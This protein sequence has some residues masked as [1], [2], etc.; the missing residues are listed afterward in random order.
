MCNKTDK[1]MR[2]YGQYSTYL[3]DMHNFKK[4]KNMRV[5]LTIILSLL[6]LS[7]FSQTIEERE[8]DLKAI[9]SGEQIG[10][11]MTKISELLAVDKF[12]STAIELKLD[13]YN[14][15]N[16]KDSIKIFFDNLIDSNRN[17]PFPYLL[18]VKFARFES[19][20]DDEILNCL[21]TAFSIDSSNVKVNYYLAKIYYNLF[22]KDQL[23]NWRKTEQSNDYA[24]NTIYFIN[25]TCSINKNYSETL[26]YPFVQLCNYLGDTDN[27]DIYDRFIDKSSYFPTTLF[28]NLPSDWA[29]NY[30]TNLMD[31]IDG[32]NLNWYSKHLK[33]MKEPVLRDSLPVKVFRF[34]WL[35]TFDNPI[36][37]RLENDKGQTTLFWKV[38]DG[39]GGYDPG[40]MIINEKKKLTKEEWK[41]IYEEINSINFWNLIPNQRMMGFD[42]AQWILEGNEFGK[43]HVVDRWNGMEIR[44]VCLDLLKLTDLEIE[45]IY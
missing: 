16:Q 8:L 22:N 32:S 44:K 23:S 13:I 28:V 43:Y 29:T 18:R 38:C 30:M 17:S 35:R 10:N 4:M 25:K 19:L 2:M 26:K 11:P 45:E 37:I 31:R 5:I 34:L 14:R 21:K 36:V 1:L 27:I 15:L 39:K 9:F 7:S 33:T 12:N 6:M 41:I 20:K 42:G 3:G 24:K 40:K